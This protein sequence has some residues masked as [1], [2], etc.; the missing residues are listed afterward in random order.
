MPS[1]FVILSK[2][3]EG[4]NN[5]LTTA[6]KDMVFG[7]NKNVNYNAN[8]V[9]SGTQSKPNS[10][11]HNST[12]HDSGG[13]GNTTSNDGSNIND[14]DRGSYSSYDTTK[15]TSAQLP[16]TFFLSLAV[17]MGVSMFL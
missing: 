3:I 1:N 16:I 7:V 4:Y 2:K 11:T 15:T 6:T 9:T 8:E 17:G 12:S 13:G 14:N 5:V 10:P